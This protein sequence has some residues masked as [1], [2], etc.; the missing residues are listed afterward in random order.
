[1][2]SCAVWIHRRRIWFFVDVM[3][4]TAFR[5]IWLSLCILYIF[6]WHSWFIVAT[7]AR[8]FAFATNSFSSSWWVMTKVDFLSLLSS[9]QFIFI[10]SSVSFIHFRFSCRDVL[11]SFDFQSLLSVKSLRI[12]CIIIS[13]TS[14]D[15]QEF[16]FVIDLCWCCTIDV[17]DLLQCSFL[18]W[19]QLDVQ[20][21]S[22]IFHSLWCISY[23]DFMTK[24]RA[25][26]C[27]VY[28]LTCCHWRVSS[29]LNDCLHDLLF[30][31]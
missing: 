16:M 7:S 2:F 4:F 14:S 25:C 27:K 26:H 21:L 11:R 19:S 31:H 28:L 18:H 29:R 9:S 15:F 1:M 6:S 23:D 10:C 3:T 13:I 17:D 12:R 24:Q 20:T 22:M 8:C 5:K 30:N